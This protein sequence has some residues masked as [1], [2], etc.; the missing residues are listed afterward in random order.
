MM[1]M[2]L[3]PELQPPETPAPL[4]AWLAQRP[5]PAAPAMQELPRTSP[6]LTE[7]PATRDSTQV[8][9]VAAKY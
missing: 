7:P 6:F 2:G 9:G 4:I 5:L 1:H 8:C 3:V